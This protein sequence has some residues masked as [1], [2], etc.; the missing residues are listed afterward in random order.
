MGQTQREADGCLNTHLAR[1][2]FANASNQS[3]I[4]GLKHLECS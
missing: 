3:L 1:D 2:W 4:D